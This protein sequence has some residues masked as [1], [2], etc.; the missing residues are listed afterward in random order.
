MSLHIAAHRP[1]FAFVAAV[2]IVSCGY[3][4]TSANDHRDHSEAITDDATLT[5]LHLPVSPGY[6]YEDK[7]PVIIF[8]C[9]GC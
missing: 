5:P 9:Q 1:E 6:I 7:L 4:R 8:L 2:A 3:R